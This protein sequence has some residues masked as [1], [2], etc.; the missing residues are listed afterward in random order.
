[1][2]KVR[3]SRLA[4]EIL[5]NPLWDEFFEEM[6]QDLFVQFCIQD[7]DYQDRIKISIAVDMIGDLKTKCEAKLMDGVKLNIVGDNNG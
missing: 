2:D 7:L 3:R 6:K 4:E 1:M 5:N